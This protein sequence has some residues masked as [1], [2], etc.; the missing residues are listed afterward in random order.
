[1]LLEDQFN[2]MVITKGHKGTAIYLNGL[3]LV[4][5]Q[6]S[7]ILSSNHTVYFGYNEKY[8]TSLNGY[9]YEIEFFNRQVIDTEV[10]LDFSKFVSCYNISSQNET[11][12]SSHGQCLYFDECEC[13]GW[14][15]NDCSIPFLS[16]SF[17]TDTYEDSVYLVS[18]GSEILQCD[19][20][21]IIEG[22]NGEKALSFNGENSKIDIP[23]NSTIM[24][25]SNDFSLS[26]WIFKAPSQEPN[27]Q[28][29]F[30]FGSPCF[31][32][33]IA[34]QTEMT[35]R[36]E[37][38]TP[39][40]DHITI[41]GSLHNNIY[42]MLAVT[43]SSIDGLKIFID[44]N[45]VADIYLTESWWLF[46][47]DIRIPSTIGYSPISNG[48]FFNGSISNLRLVGAVMTMS[49]VEQV[50]YEQ[51][52]RCFG[53]PFTYFSVC[54]GHGVCF[55]KDSCEC[56]KHSG[57]Y[58]QLCGDYDCFGVSSNLSSVCTSNGYCEYP[59]SCYEGYVGL[60]CS[61]H[62]CNGTTFLAPNVC[63]GNGK[64]TSVNHCECVYG[65]HGFN[66]QT[67]G[68]FGIPRDNE[69]SYN[70]HLLRGECIGVDTCVCKNGY[71]ERIVILP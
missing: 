58:G 33:I 2:L 53:L 5:S 64:C 8:L 10:L 20:C 39:D 50:R 12:C 69:K 42:Y 31:W 66:C 54:N 41:T 48:E 34:I 4:I 3:P 13:Y 35:Y 38:V 46:K 15:G 32:Q 28:Q 11:V 24:F 70:A 60:N 37:L 57:Y 65:Y 71:F 18:D 9:I 7:G 1:M 14:I 17:H 27:R 51:G 61:Q 43:K 22:V 56:F 16:I 63:S 30:Y 49:E 67:Q 62:T 29:L 40:N 68:C 47:K 21:I 36:L 52:P 25:L 55:R 45:E 6:D 19:D 23:Q 59:D 44:G 26:C